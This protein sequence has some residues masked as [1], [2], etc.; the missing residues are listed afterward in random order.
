MHKK[1]LFY[2]IVAGVFWGSA[3]IF[4][5]TLVS[6]GFTAIQINALR[7]IVS[8]IV[9]TVYVAVANPKGFKVTFK[10]LILFLIN[11]IAVFL[12]GAAY[13]E[14]MTYTTS[15]T[16]VV[17]MYT[18]PIFVMI[19][20]VLF[21]GERITK[22]KMFA[23]LLTFAGCGLISGIVGGVKFNPYG[24]FM[25]ILAGVLYATYNLLSKIIMNRK[26]NALVATMY[27][28]MAG[29]VLG[30]LLGNP[31]EIIMTIESDVL[32]ILPWAIGV[33]VC[34]SA[35]PYFLYTLAS[36]KLPASVA[37]ALSS[38]EP[39]TASLISFTIYGEK[40]GVQSILGIAAIVT[41]VVLLSKNDNK[42][43]IK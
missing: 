1:S 40:A 27:G 6:F 43:S 37:S 39:L 15:A 3:V 22:A 19:V 36:K 34:T 11:G 7:A 26:N 16:A 29:S 12:T 35:L 2:I 23:V 38:I 10:E 8:A 9:L 30:L 4:K 18:A 17:L 28:F 32:R 14:S 31:G 42:E 21:M 33:G 25:G 13:Y 5:N 41:A 20:S 24:F